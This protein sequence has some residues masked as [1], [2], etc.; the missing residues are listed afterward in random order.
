MQEL[1]IEKNGDMLLQG[2]SLACPTGASYRASFSLL[3]TRKPK[4]LESRRT[5]D[6]RLLLVVVAA[7]SCLSLSCSEVLRPQDRVKDTTAS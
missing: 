3:S 1:V 4:A 2:W 6:S 7:N 5:S